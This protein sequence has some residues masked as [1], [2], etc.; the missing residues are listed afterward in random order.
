MVSSGVSASHAPVRTATSAS[1]A[2]DLTF[3]TASA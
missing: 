1:R 2:T 3:R